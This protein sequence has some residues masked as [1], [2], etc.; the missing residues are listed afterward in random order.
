MGQRKAESS[1]W[2]SQPL[3]IPGFWEKSFPESILEFQ[4]NYLLG[5]SL[6]V[7]M[8]LNVLKTTHMYC[9][10]DIKIYS[11]LNNICY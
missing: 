7:G 11:L 4:Q 9:L 6:V 5:P 10:L 8:F 2:L 1:N 3:E